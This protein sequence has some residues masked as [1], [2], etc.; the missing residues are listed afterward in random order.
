MHLGEGRASRGGGACIKGRTSRRY[1]GGG[2]V[3]L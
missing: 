1:K 2:G 3:H